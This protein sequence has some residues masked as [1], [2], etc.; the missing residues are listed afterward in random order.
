MDTESGKKK[1]SHSRNAIQKKKSAFAFWE[2]NGGHVR[3]Q[4]TQQ[5]LTD[6]F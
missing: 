6:I 3:V 5:I 2:I 1:K 4:K